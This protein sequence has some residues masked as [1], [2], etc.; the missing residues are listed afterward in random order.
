[1]RLREEVAEI[2][3]GDGLFGILTHPV[4]APDG[5]LPVLIL[6]DVGLTY[7][8]GH[9]RAHTDLARIFAG[10]GFR[11]LRFDFSGVGD[12]PVRRDGLPFSESAIE[13]VR[14]VMDWLEQR[15]GATRF[16]VAG[17]CSGGRVGFRTALQDERIVGAALLNP[18]GLQEEDYT[19]LREIAE[20]RGTLRSLADW[21]R[22][23]RALTGRTHYVA[24]L[25]RLFGA[26]RRLAG[27]G[28]AVPSLA[29]EVQEGLD[30]GLRVGFFFSEREFGR[31][32]VRLALGDQYEQ[33][34][35][36]PGMLE[37]VIE[38]SDHMFTWSRPREELFESLV[39]WSA[40][41]VGD[42]RS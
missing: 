28:S 25:R 11:V 13:E 32:Y 21:G 15:L 12:S 7:R 42:G 3:E 38:G 17:I 40:Y 24:V 35:A 33:I 18:R 19:E 16:L 30:R 10:R 36:H 5:G 29:G 37:H 14:A 23:K 20:A 8:S 31:T 2:P 22:W 27:E 34:L 1:M 4:R 39:T 9:A 6:L 41:W 26:A